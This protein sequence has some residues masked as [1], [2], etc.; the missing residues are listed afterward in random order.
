MNNVLDHN[1]YRFFQSD[2]IPTKRVPSYPLITM[3]GE[4]ELP[5]QGILLYFSYDG[6]YVYKK[7][8]FSDLKRKLDIVKRRK[9]R[10]N[11]AIPSMSGFS[12]AHNH[13]HDANGNHEDHTEG[14]A[15][16]V[17]HQLKSS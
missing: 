7:Y 11:Y 15:H 6:Y 4:Q 3:L 16:T 2:L 10:L 9:L 5:M 8:L 12:Q 1:G 17:Y 14:T 13:E